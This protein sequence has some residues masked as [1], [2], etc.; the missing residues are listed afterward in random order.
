VIEQTVQF[1]R[2]LAAAMVVLED[3]DLVAMER[4]PMPAIPC[5]SRF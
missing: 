3:V 2:A 4:G 1:A 5:C